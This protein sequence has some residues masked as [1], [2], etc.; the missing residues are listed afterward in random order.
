[1]ID[2]EDYFSNVKDRSKSRNRHRYYWN[3]ITHYCNY[4]SHEEYSV[5]EIGVGTGELLHQIKGKRKVGIDF[6]E[7]MIEHAKAKHPELELHVMPA[8]EISLN[9]TFDIIIISN[10]IGFVDDV[11]LIFEQLKKVSHERTKIIVTYYNF[12][13]EPLIKFAEW[14]GLKSKS[15]N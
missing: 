2:R 4:F 10:L 13:W 15:P 6:S 14:I 3:D 7:K 11:Q 5:L 1:M 8:E 9:E 12:L